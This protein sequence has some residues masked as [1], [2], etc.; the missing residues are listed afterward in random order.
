M[1]RI[2]LHTHSLASDGSLSA[3]ELVMLA[4]R[5]GVDFMALTDHDTVA[6]VPAAQ[7][8]GRKIGVKVIAGVELS[9]EYNQGELHVLGYNPDINNLALNEC[10]EKLLN[11]R[12]QRNPLIIERLRQLGI[13]VTLAQVA[14]EAGGKV[15]GRPHFA[16][17]L[18]KMGVAASVA[19][20]FE[21]F[22]AVGRPAYVKKDKVSPEEGVKLIREAGGIPVIAH[23][24]H[25]PV[26]GSAE[27][28]A[29]ISRLIPFGLLGIEAY[30]PEH[31][32]TNVRRFV[33]LAAEFGL[34]VTGGSDFHGISKPQNRLGQVLPDGGPVPEGVRASLEEWI[35]LV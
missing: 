7:A 23:P 17:V 31:S 30:Y 24:G 21:K 14:R 15:I 10:L 4:H 33:R 18:V 20:A 25:L 27:L 16:R 26:I 11:Y 29:L 32:W 19:E 13:P 9:T 1:R 3:E 6:G 28:T 5:I 8:M 34:L 35:N 22:L 2:D 12:H